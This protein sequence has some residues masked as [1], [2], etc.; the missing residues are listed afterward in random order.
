MSNLVIYKEL[1]S[2][3]KAL[4]KYSTMISDLRSFFSEKE[5]NRAINCIMRVM[6]H[7]NI[8]SKQI[9]VVKNTNCKFTN[10]QVLSLRILFPF[11]IVKDSMPVHGFPTGQDVQ[12]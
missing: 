12:M 2:N 4:D 3:F 1:N 10:L 8:R 11:F 7:I 9:G 5:N 6:E